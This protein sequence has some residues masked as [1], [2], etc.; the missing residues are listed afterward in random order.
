MNTGRTMELV[1]L[2]DGRWQWTCPRCSTVL[3]SRGRDLLAEVAIDHRCQFTAAGL[4]NL[5]EPCP[6]GGGMVQ[7]PAWAR[8]WETH[9]RDELPANAADLLDTGLLV[10]GEAIPPE[11]VP[12]PQCHGSG[13]RPTIP[14]RVLL[15][16]LARHR[17]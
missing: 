8:W 14:G 11:E 13:R 7:H 3:T 12:C 4:P 2:D 17:P 5:D 1:S 9:A 6:C 16:F 10:P 15:D